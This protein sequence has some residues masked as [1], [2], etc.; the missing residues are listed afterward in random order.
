M[1]LDKII[2]RLLAALRRENPRLYTNIVTNHP[3]PL[4]DTSSPDH[5]YWSSDECFALYDELLKLLNGM[6]DLEELLNQETN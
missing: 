3:R 2:P 1:T 4:E 5:P 6:V